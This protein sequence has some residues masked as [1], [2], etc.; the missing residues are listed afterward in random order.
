MGRIEVESEGTL[1]VSTPPDATALQS[2]IDECLRFNQDKRHPNRNGMDEAALLNSFA[3]TNCSYCRFPTLQKF[4]YTGNGIQRYRCKD[5]G[6]TFTVLT[7][8]I[9]DG[10][11]TNLKQWLDFLCCIFSHGFINFPSDG[12][13][14]N[15]IRYWM[16]KVFLVLRGYQDSLVLKDD[17]QM[18]EIYYKPH[19]YNLEGAEGGNRGGVGDRICIGIACD[20]TNVIC[21]VEGKGRATKNGIRSIFA[22][23]ITYGATLSHSMEQAHNTLV[24][25]L[26]LESITYDVREIKKL[27]DEANP[28]H[29]INQY[30]R[31]LK[32]FLRSH[33]ALIGDNLQ[34][35][36]NFF[37]FMMNPPHDKQKKIEEFMTRALH[38]RIT[39]RYRG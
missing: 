13:A 12:V 34:D 17:V 30:S 35:Y 29:M 22:S 33:A 23:H 32:M 21:F 11:K 38:C 37:S 3:A 25:L 20:D 31:K 24:E 16:E 27:P 19:G 15:T 26:E 14:V 28:L 2:F 9:F 7:E 8:T 1:L 36:L 6:K 5:C 4:G 39:H 10:H 18:D